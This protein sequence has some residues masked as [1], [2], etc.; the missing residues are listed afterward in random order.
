MALAADGEVRRGLLD[1][2]DEGHEDGGGNVPV[3]VDEAQVAAAPQAEADSQRV[4]LALVDRQVDHLDLRAQLAEAGVAAV[5]RAVRDGDDLEG[6]LALAK[7][8]D[9]LG[10]VTDEIGPRV[11]IGDDD[12]QLQLS[13]A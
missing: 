5:G 9:D 4:A 3:A 2:V 10:H 1:A 8:L 11:V 13:L 6:D 7:Q 12:R